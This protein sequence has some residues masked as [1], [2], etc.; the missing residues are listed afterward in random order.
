MKKRVLLVAAFAALSGGALAQGFRGGMMRM[1]QGG[2]MAQ[3]AILNRADVQD[4]IKLSDDQKAKLDAQRAGIRQRMQALFAGGG[5]FGGSDEERKAMQSKVQAVFEDV[6]KEALGVLTDDQRKRVKELYVQSA[7][8]LAVLQPDVAKE[9]EITAAQ[10]AKFDDL[11][12][13]QDEATQGLFEQVQSGDIDRE[14]MQASVAKNAKV[15]DAEVTKV[16]TS[17]QRDKLKAMGGM[18]FEFK[19]PKPGTPG[20]FGRPGGGG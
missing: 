20:A 18:P 15:M 1:F 7:G 17:A 14:Q 6:S 16:L 12:R 5:G 2:P 10:K 4:E 13:L 3:A 8:S 11:Q 19:D 9:I